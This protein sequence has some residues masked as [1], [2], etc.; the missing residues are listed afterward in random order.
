MERGQRAGACHLRYELGIDVL[1][2]AKQQFADDKILYKR[3]DNLQS[4]ILSFHSMIKWHTCSNSQ[5]LKYCEVGLRN[6][7]CAPHA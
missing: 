2:I 3:T 4:F 7:R 5:E 6:E 1:E